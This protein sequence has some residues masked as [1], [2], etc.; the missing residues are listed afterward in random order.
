MTSATFDGETFDAPRDEVRLFRQLHSV[1]DLMLDGQWRTLERISDETGEPVASVSAR[2]RDLRKPKF[3]GYRVDRE[4]MSRGVW[5][6][7]VVIEKA[8]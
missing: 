8:A 1:H 6:Y 5:R 2:L 7:R 3:G 4:Y